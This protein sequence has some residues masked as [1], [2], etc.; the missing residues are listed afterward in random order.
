LI[1][2]LPPRIAD[3]GRIIWT[4]DGFAE[5]KPVDPVARANFPAL[6]TEFGEGCT[7]YGYVDNAGNV[8]I[9]RGNLI[10]NLAAW[11]ALDWGDASFTEIQTAWLVLQGQASIVKAGGPKEWPGGGYFAK[12]T[13]IR[14][15]QASLDALVQARLDEFDA[16]L[17]AEWPG[18]DD[19]PP[20][21][22][23]VLMRLAWACGTEGLKGVNRHGWPK[24]W[25]YWSAKQWGS[26]GC[27]D[28]CSIPA[29]DETEP[30]ANA[31]AKALFLGCVNPTAA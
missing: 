27:A 12:F 24:L 4:L 15:T 31:K 8:T 2:S 1:P 17:R 26:P 18:W 7:D 14:A 9:G 22:Q 25:A 23:S 5:E 29:L 19:A 21:A 30:G 3:L 13:T 16:A 6:V 10:P 28:E 20:D 11:M